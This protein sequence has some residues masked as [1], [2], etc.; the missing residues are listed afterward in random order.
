MLEEHRVEVQI[1]VVLIDEEADVE[2]RRELSLDC[3]ADA[4]GGTTAAET[5]PRGRCVTVQS[6]D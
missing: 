1:D 4:G 3:A 6:L 5:R 2:L